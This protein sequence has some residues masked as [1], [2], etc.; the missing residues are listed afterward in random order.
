MGSEERRMP[1]RRATYCSSRYVT[2]TPGSYGPYQSSMGSIV[3]RAGT[4]R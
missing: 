3:S 4:R 1:A 2:T